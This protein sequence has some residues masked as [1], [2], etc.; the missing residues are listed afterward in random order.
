MSFENEI[1]KKYIKTMVLRYHMNEDE[2]QKTMVP[3][4]NELKDPTVKIKN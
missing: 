2:L 4:Q 3:P 1:G